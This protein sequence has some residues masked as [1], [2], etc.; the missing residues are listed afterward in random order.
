M[1]SKGLHCVDVAEIQDA[2]T[3]EFKKPEK[4]GIFGSFSEAVTAQKPVCVCVCVYINGADF[5]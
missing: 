2:V 4:R 1:K 5:K 3:D